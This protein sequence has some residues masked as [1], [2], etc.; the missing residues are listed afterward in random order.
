MDKGFNAGAMRYAGVLFLMI[1]LLGTAG[2]VI[3]G[4]GGGDAVNVM[5][6]ETGQG[7]GIFLGQITTDGGTVNDTD[8]VLQAQNQEQVQ[9][10]VRR[11]IAGGGHGN[12][13]L[14]VNNLFLERNFVAV[15]G[16]AAMEGRSW[17]LL[18]IYIVHIYM[19]RH[20]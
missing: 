20:V 2:L 19:E 14:I 8:S 7:T 12:M 15:N 13:E 3:Q 10:P 4:C 6:T 18:G 17:N 9:L 16:V 1:A 5:L 11:S